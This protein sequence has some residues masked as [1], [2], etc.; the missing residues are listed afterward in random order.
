VRR[1]AAAGRRAVAAALLFLAIAC[2]APRPSAVSP[3]GGGEAPALPTIRF[4]HGG[5]A[6]DIPVEVT[7]AGFLLVATRVDGSGPWPFL[8]DT[9]DGPA[10]SHRALAEYGIE[11]PGPDREGRILLKDVWFQVLG[12]EAW[13][14]EVEMRDA[15]PLDA[16]AGRRCDG[17]LGRAFLSRFVV[18]IDYPRST[19]A[20]FEPRSFSYQGPGDVLPIEVEQGL[21]FVQAEVALA[22]RRPVAGR[23]LLATASAEAVRLFSSPA[24][25][26]SEA[27]EPLAAEAL[28]IG[29]R[30]VWGPGAVS[31]TAPGN[32]PRAAGSIGSSVLR[33]F[34]VIL[35]Y[36]RQRMILAP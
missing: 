3:A 9:T 5:S 35:D 6:R 2:A 17:V 12:A 32:A 11:P 20:L 4:T 30:A 7:P 15:E 33:R 27:A 34:K 23:F 21:P 10:F 36:S 13:Q 8:V 16:A 1:R 19:L 26:G 22:G 24:A 31:S 14:P 25:A 28:R 29:R 18:E